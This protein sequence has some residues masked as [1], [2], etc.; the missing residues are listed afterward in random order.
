M[1][2][3]TIAM[4]S[5][6]VPMGINAIKSGVQASQ[7]KKLAQTQRPDYQIPEEALQALNQAKYLSG[8]TELPGQNLMEARIGQNLS[9]GVSELERVSTNPADLASNVAKMYMSGNESIN[10]IG[11][12]AGQ[13]YLRNQG[14][15]TD[16]LGTMAGYRDKQFDIN[17]MQPYE[18]NMAAAAALREGSFRN[19]SAAGQDLSSGLSGYA[20][21]EYYQNML[22]DLNKSGTKTNP[23]LPENKTYKDE[24][25]TIKTVD[26]KGAG[27]YKPKNTNRKT[28]NMSTTD[29]DYVTTRL[30][31][32]TNQNVGGR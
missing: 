9:K 14:L 30:P 7:A 10:D 4:L 13:Q 25:K 20:N 2:P 19:A 23:Y 21:M 3:L 22:N 15:L 12:Q 18:N 8:M 32:P 17:E 24:F 27:V 31:R 5:K 1:D 29:D 11:L 16:A 28:F 6:L 26:E